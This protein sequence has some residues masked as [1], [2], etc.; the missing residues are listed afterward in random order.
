MKTDDVDTKIIS[1]LQQN[2]R[3]SNTELAKQ[4]NLTEGAIRHRIDQLIKKGV[5]THFTIEVS[6]KNV[7]C[8]VIMVKSKSDVKKMMQEILKLTLAVHAYEISGD[9][10]ACLIVEGE[11][12]ASIDARIDR[13]RELKTVLDTKTF[14]VLKKWQ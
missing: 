8:A 6:E 4:I 2:S 9:F 11:D 5:I 14:V 12:L 7:L 13:L 3:I 1:I 10:D